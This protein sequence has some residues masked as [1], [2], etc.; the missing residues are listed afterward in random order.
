MSI[1][2]HSHMTTLL[3][4]FGECPACDAVWQ[5]SVKPQALRDKRAAYQKTESTQ[6]SPEAHNTVIANKEDKDE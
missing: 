5:A 3:S 4:V 1:V 2:H 6:I